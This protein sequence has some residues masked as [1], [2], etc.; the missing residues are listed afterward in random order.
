MLEAA[1]INELRLLRWVIMIFELDIIGNIRFIIMIVNI[2]F[3]IMI[4]VLNMIIMSVIIYRLR[5]W[6]SIDNIR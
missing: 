5:L 3:I 4:I 2:R 6:L 1:I